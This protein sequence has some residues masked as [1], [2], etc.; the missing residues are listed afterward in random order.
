MADQQSR[1]GKKTGTGDANEGKQHVHAGEQ[2]HRS[3]HKKAEDAE[4]GAKGGSKNTE[5]KE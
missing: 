1:G 2:E 5:K 4:R 3:E